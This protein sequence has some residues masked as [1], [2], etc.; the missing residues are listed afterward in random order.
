VDPKLVVIVVFS[1][2]Y[3]LFE[4][5]LNL[6]QVRRSTVTASGDRRS[7]VVM[8]I[9]IT[10][11]YTLAFAIGAT[12]VGRIHAWN[13]FF[14]AGGALALAGLGIRVS[15]LL[16]LGRQFV[17]TVARVED[18]HLVTSGLYGSIRNPGYL[19][20]LLIFLGISVSVSNGLSILAM[21]IPVT[22][23]Y[24]YRIKVEETF[25]AEQFGAAYREYKGRTKRLLPLVY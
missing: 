2:L 8:Y 3:A 12:R 17:H 14:A 21:M 7:L 6:R 15:A 11:G 24:L 10:V 13:A 23:A 5:F 1:C 4:V 20:Q 16:T 25:M 19:G 18:H 22:I 9:L